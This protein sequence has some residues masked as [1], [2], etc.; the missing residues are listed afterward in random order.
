MLFSQQ[1]LILNA[2]P[3]AAIVGMFFS[4]SAD[5]N[6]AAEKSMAFSHLIGGLAILALGWVTSFWAFFGLMLIHCLL[7]VPTLSI[8]NSIAF[9]H[10]KDAKKEFGLV[11]MGGTIGWVLA[12][13]PFVF[14]MVDWEKVRGTNTTGFVDWLGTV[15]GTP[16]TGDALK[17]S[18]RWTYV[19]AGVASLVLAAFSLILP[20]TPPKTV[21]ETTTLGGHRERLAWLEHL[22]VLLGIRSSWS[23][24]SRPCPTRSYTTVISTGPGEFPQERDGRH[25]GESVQLR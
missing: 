10:M 17:Q 12:A 14:I 1:S 22:K 7:Y 11:R 18:T 9:T 2:F 8:S 15:L 19:V 3:I 25:Q 4:T 23:C 16:L 6:F 24:G 5:C 13:W 21:D 20:H